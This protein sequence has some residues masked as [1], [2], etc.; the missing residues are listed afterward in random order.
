MKTPSFDVRFELEGWTLFW[1]DVELTDAGQDQ[2]PQL[3]DDVARRVRARYERSALT[4]DPTVTALRKLFRRAG[5]DPTRY[6]P[7]SEALLRRLVKGEPIPAI[8]P[9]VDIN[10]CLSAELAVPCCVMAE[11][12]FEPPYV[13]RAGA[14]GESYISLRGPI[15]LEGKPLL[16]DAAGPLDTPITGN[17]RVKVTDDTRRGWMV[18]YCP[19]ET[20]EADMVGETLAKLADAAPVIKILEMAASGH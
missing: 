7:S 3:L 17:E 6:R 14:P 20:V 18:V 11:G 13:F 15:N 1:A 8:H 16:C 10:N 12:T 2:L 9:F 4:D 5:T 19:S